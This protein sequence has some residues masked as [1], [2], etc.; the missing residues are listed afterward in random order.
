MSDICGRCKSNFAGDATFSFK[1]PSSNRKT[2]VEIKLCNQCAYFLD[3]KI[4]HLL[5]MKGGRR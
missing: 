4:R 2:N 3:S 1:R 5:H